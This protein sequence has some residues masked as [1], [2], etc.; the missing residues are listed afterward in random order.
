MV[1]SFHNLFM[2]IVSKLGI[3]TSH[4]FLTNVEDLTDVLNRTVKMKIIHFF[5]T[6]TLKKLE[7]LYINKIPKIRAF[8]RYPD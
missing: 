4:V 8:K 2:D 7:E 3:K 5:S 6:R 1:K